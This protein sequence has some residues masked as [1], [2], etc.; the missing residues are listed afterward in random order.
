MGSKFF[1]YGEDFL[2]LL[3]LK[4]EL[5]CLLRSLNDDTPIDEC[6]I[7]YR[8]SFGRG[9]L[10]GEF[11]AIITT[12]S[13]AY[14]VESKWDNL[15]DNPLTME[16]RKNQLDR[17]KILKWISKR[18][19]GENW[20]L[21]KEKYGENFRSEF[22]GKYIPSSDSILSKNLMTI[23]DE[24]KGKSINNVMFYFFR[25]NRPGNTPECFSIIWFRYKTTHKN[26]IGLD[27][28]LECLRS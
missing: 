8:P 23:L 27:T 21:F 3:A 22:L 5:G 10:Y 9:A 19:K 16:L 12:K 11:D 17:H 13:K 4:D 7:F 14:L 15:N 20:D 18:W 26:F 25:K 2:T 1:G 24:L 28:E 6:K